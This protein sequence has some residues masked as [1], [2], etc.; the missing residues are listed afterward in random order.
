MVIVDERIGSRELLQDIRN[1]GVQAELAR[2]DGADFQFEGNGPDGPILIGIERKAIQDLCTCIRDGRLEGEQLPKFIPTYDVHYLVVEGYWRKSWKTGLLE[3]YNGDWHLARGSYNYAEVD[4]FLCR[5]ENV[6]GIHLWRTGDEQE[7]A[8]WIAGRYKW[9]SK[10]WHRHRAPGA[11]Y[12]PEPTIQRKGNRASLYIYKATL[13]DKWVHDL[14]HIEGRAIEI[15]KNFQ[16]GIDMA[17]AP[18]E[19]WKSIKGLGEKSARDIVDAI[20]RCRQD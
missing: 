3:V 9:W 1:L 10:E 16:S 20:K 13:L 12:A 8:S 5:L 19:R 6:Y 4:A 7:T 11:I 14:P 18:Y 2:L 17:A 15:A